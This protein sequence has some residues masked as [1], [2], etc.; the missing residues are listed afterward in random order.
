MHHLATHGR[1]SKGRLGCD[2]ASV[3]HMC[4]LNYGLTG[5]L[6]VR[7]T[8][9]EK[10]DGDVAA[11]VREWTSSVPP[12]GRIVVDLSQ[13]RTIDYSGLAVLA[14]ALEKT[15][16]SAHFRGL[17]DKQVKLLRYLGRDVGELCSFADS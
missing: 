6:V 12:G 17:T 10:L 4:E 15:P 16:F 11:Q 7:F 8:E 9:D 13:V 2:A 5:D 3:K 14:A 1:P